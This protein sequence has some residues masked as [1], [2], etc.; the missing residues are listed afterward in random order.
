M[1][2]ERIC[3]IQLSSTVSSLFHCHWFSYHISTNVVWSY[4]WMTDGHNYTMLNVQSWAVWEPEEFV[5]HYYSGKHS[6]MIV[7][8]RQLGSLCIFQFYSIQLQKFSHTIVRLFVFTLCQCSK[9]AIYTGSFHCWHF[10]CYTSTNEFGN[11]CRTE[12]W[13]IS[14]C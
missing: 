3:C 5:S 2:E 4:T 10:P 9:V 8:W 14:V 13:I 12:Q 6:T 11:V 7:W 1:F